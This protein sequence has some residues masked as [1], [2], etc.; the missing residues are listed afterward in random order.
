MSYAVK[1]KNI[2][3]IN[4]QPQQPLQILVLNKKKVQYSVRDA[5]SHLTG[6]RNLVRPAKNTVFNMGRHDRESMIMTVV[7]RRVAL[8]IQR[9]DFTYM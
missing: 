1:S 9:A 7:G 8:R 4:S 3:C 2:H 6:I 5:L